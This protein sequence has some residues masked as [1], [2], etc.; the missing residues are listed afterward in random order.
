MCVV[1]AMYPEN[2]IIIHEHS[3]E[4]DAC[5]ALVTHPDVLGVHVPGIKM[6]VKEL[7]DAVS[8]KAKVRYT[9]G[10]LIVGV[11]PNI[12]IVARSFGV[13]INDMYVGTQHGVIHT[14]DISLR[15]PV[16]RY[17]LMA[18]DLTVDAAVLD[19]ELTIDVVYLQPQAVCRLMHMA[20][21]LNFD[22]S[23]L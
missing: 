13:F 9:F 18:Y 1:T 6:K 7:L 3:P 16:N 17:N 4:L 23:K 11:R 2:I 21:G 20:G 19:E 10:D 22:T 8:P 5:T 14:A 12:D 15:S